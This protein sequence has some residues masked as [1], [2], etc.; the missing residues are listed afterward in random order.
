MDRRWTFPQRGLVVVFV[1]A[2]GSIGSRAFAQGA[3]APGT[4]ILPGVLNGG[5]MSGQLHDA[6]WQAMHSVATLGWSGAGLGSVITDTPNFWGFGDAI[7]VC[8]G[9]DSTQ[10]G[11]NHMGSGAGAGRGESGGMTENSWF[12]LTQSWQTT[13]AFAGINVGLLTVQAG[14]DTS[15]GGD[16]CFS[17]FF[18]TTGNTG[19]SRLGATAVGGLF[20]ATSPAAWPILW[21]VSLSWGPG[22]VVLPNKLGT[23]AGDP[24]IVHLAVP[25]R[26][27]GNTLLA[28]VIFEVQG[29]LNGP[30]LGALGEQ[31]FLSSTVEWEGVTELPVDP[32][33]GIRGTGG[34]TNGNGNMSSDVFTA[35]AGTT[36][37]VS[38]TRWFGNDD[39]G[40]ALGALPTPLL[41]PLVQQGSSFRTGRIEF[42]QQLAFKT[43]FYWA[44][45]TLN[46]PPCAGHPTGVAASGAAVSTE[47]G[48]VSGGGGPDWNVTG[49]SPH[50]PLSAIELFQIDHKA[51]AD[52]NFDI[53]MKIGTVTTVGGLTTVCGPGREACGF[54]GL[55][56]G[57]PGFPCIFPAFNRAQFFW[58]LTPADCMLQLGGS[59][60]C[61]GPD[62]SEGG[63]ISIGTICEGTQVIPIAFD[64]LTLALL[65]GPLAFGTPRTLSDDFF[66]DGPLPCGGQFYSSVFEGMFL[67]YRSGI[68]ELTPKDGKLQ[69]NTPDPTL[70]GLRLFLATTSTRFNLCNGMFETTRLSNA[71][72]ISLQ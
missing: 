48:V 20:P 53:Y 29:A 10:G 41:T 50:R 23:D 44:S 7:R 13:N 33:H 70:K 18:H 17:P 1:L 28:N 26:G 62:A 4:G 55:Y 38:H 11:R 31:Y 61:A 43:P 16:A 71:L 32:V 59:W 40:V 63:P 5:S 57:I 54:Q 47:P 34:V 2:A 14:S 42:L 15:L 60:S 6:N 66:W 45:H 72:T 25:P 46:G 35:G 67:P 51:G 24:G 19:G 37:A 39:A 9:I 56:M 68:S 49:C 52:P 64:T 58:S 22:T 21:E 8:Y 36:G 65:T 69:I 30:A 12:R 27:L 3:P